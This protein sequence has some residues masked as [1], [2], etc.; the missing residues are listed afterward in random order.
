M[1]TIYDLCV[2]GF[3][4]DYIDNGCHLVCFCVL[5]LRYVSKYLSFLTGR[6]TI[7]TTFVASVSTFRFNECATRAAAAPPPF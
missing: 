7:Y 6:R 4:Y 1:V 2:V 3:K 5:V